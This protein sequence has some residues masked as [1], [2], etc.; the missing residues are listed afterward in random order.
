[1]G[2][3]QRIGQAW[4]QLGQKERLALGLVALFILLFFKP[5]VSGDGFGYYVELEGAVRFHTLN[6]SNEL[7]YNDVTMGQTVWWHPVTQKFV[8]QYAPGLPL[9]GVPLYA[10]SLALDSLPPAHVSDAFFLKERGDILVHQASFALTALL[11][12]AL[13]TVALL[14]TLKALGFGNNAGVAVALTFF[15]S[16]LARYATYDLTYTHAAEAGLMALALYFFFKDQ[17]VKTGAFLGLMALV[18]YTSI[19][20]VLPFVAFY[21]WKKRPAD[22]GKVVAAT[23]PFIVLA[24]LYSWAQYGSPLAT[25]YSQGSHLEQNVDLPVFV[26]TVLFSLEGNPPGLLWWSPLLFLSAYGL[27]K[28]KDER[29]WVLLGVAALMLLV[30]GSFFKGTTGFSFSNRYFAALFALLAIGTAV[31]L[32]EGR[33]RKLLYALSAYGALLF[34]LHI[35]NDWGHFPGIAEVF[36]YWFLQGH[37]TE[38]PGALVSKLGLIRLVTKT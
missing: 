18:R 9:L 13:G 14:A 12:L 21:C 5:V 6:L 11:I 25:G 35:S 2:L 34:I 28:W 31:L 20:F 36:Q 4:A 27:W 22:A 17:P 1:M 23:M 29:K 19:V 15:G 38:L 33:H 7:H 30:T 16:P 3:R 10:A 37:L 32:K 8:S 24:M 26:P